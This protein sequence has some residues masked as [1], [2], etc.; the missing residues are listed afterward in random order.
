MQRFEVRER[1]L[2]CTSCG[3]H[4]LCRAPVPFFGPAPNYL[5]VMGEAPG[6]REDEAGQPFVGPAG[7]LLRECLRAAAIDPDRVFWVNAVSCWPHRENH[8]PTSAEVNACSGNLAAQL[9]LADPSWVCLLGGVALSTVRSDLKISRARGHVLLAGRRRYFVAFHPSYAL[10]N[11]RGEEFLRRDLQALAFMLTAD[12]WV[13]AVNDAC[14]ICGTDPETLGEHDL[15]LRFDEMGAPYC[16]ECWKT[17]SSA[18][19]TQAKEI[20]A[21]DR[22]QKRTGR[23]FA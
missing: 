3:L 23:L 2:T 17:F 9:E 16:S 8:T 10:R 11:A 4:E 14:V 5:A 7:E 15:H 13:P 12:D 20:R 22:N 19:K 18:G 6:A 21:I 1:V